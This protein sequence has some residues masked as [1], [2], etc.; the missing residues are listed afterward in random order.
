M[1]QWLTP[2]T[3]NSLKQSN[4]LYRK[5]RKNGKSENKIEYRKYKKKLLDKPIRISRNDHYAGIIK[6]AGPDSRKFNEIIN[7]KQCK[8]NHFVINN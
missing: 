1:N 2:G 8:P 7:R 4:T 3:K 6:R 5:W